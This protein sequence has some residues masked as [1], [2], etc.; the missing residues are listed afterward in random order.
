MAVNIFPTLPGQGITVH[1][2]PRWN[3]D[4]AVHA[5]GRES[6]V[7]R[8]QWPL[9]DFELTFEGL[10][11][12][13]TGYYGSLGAD[14]MQRL[15]GFYNQQQGPFTP[16]LYIDPTDYFVTAQP[17]GVGD[18]STLNFVFV[19]GFGGYVFPVGAVTNATIFINGVLQSSSSYTITNT[20]LGFPTLVFVTPP[21]NGLTVTA[22]YSFAYV[23]RFSEDVTDFEEFMHRLMLVKSIKFQSIRDTVPYSPC[24]IIV[25]T[26]SGTWTVP[27]DWNNNDNT[28][29][30]IGGGSGGGASYGG[31][32][33]AYT[34]LRN[35]VL[36]PGDVLSYT[37]GA[38]GTGL[39]VLG[40]GNSGTATN[41]NSG[42]VYADYGGHAVG[43]GSVNGGQAANCIPYKVHGV[44]VAQSGGASGEI[45]SL[46]LGGVG[47]GG[48]AGPNGPGARG[49]FP[50]V[51]AQGGG[52]GGAADGGSVGSALTSGATGGNGGASSTGVLGGIGGTFP[53]P[54][55]TDGSQGSG[56]GGGAASLVGANGSTAQNWATTGVWYGAG[57][58]GGGGGAHGV[59]PVGNGGNAGG[60]GGGGG[61]GGFSIPG[62]VYGTG[63]NAT[64]GIIIITNCNHL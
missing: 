56:G 42:M 10:D 17:L 62:N 9:W 36:T 46:G 5:S 32:G 6:R 50:S 29:E 52:G 11:A 34:I 18:G 43:A 28:I 57:S 24:G 44:Q 41:F 39:S 38:G 27:D 20:G 4:V 58:G 35:A 30:A 25:L 13:D 2:L 16:F 14:T 21:A 19:R 55:A 1:K 60:Y 49:G 61:G 3:T 54:V 48:A 22:D 15:A 26:S 7:R 37:I 59:L 64:S 8:Y 53:T 40:T 51:S 47:G 23:C 45:I 31:T 33:G 12:T 63:G